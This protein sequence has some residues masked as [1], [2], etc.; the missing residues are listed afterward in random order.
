MPR[1]WSFDRSGSAREGVVSLRPA[2]RPLRFVRRERSAAVYLDGFAGEEVRVVLPAPV[3][4][5]VETAA[6]TR[7]EVVADVAQDA[8]AVEL[9]L[10]HRDLIEPGA[11]MLF[12]FGRDDWR[13]F[14]MKN[15]RIALDMLFV[16]TDGVVVNVVQRAEP[17]TLWR[18]L[19]REPCATVLE[20]TG[21]W[22]E[23]RGVGAG[24]RV[25]VIRD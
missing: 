20:V 3:R 15:T 16:R 23:A 24:D 9:G 19:S 21:G 14:W 22:A 2:D 11:G 8:H 1:G 13:S 18:C 7:D 5:V 10:M 25:E 17:M 4:V 6:G 12:R